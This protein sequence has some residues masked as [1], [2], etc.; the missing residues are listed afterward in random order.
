M[1]WRV[2][3]AFANERL[4]KRHG[5]PFKKFPL[6]LSEWILRK[7]MEFRYNHRNQNI[8]EIL[9]KKLRNLVPDLL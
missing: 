9:T 8:F 1:A 5:V 3:K 6:Y 7:E 2:S 4:I